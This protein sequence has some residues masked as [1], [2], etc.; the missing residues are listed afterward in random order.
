MSRIQ[1]EWKISRAVALSLIAASLLAA[2]GGGSDTSAEQPSPPP[3]G[4]DSSTPPA[5]AAAKKVNTPVDPGIVT[6]DNAFGL[7]LLA[8]L[9]RRSPG[10]NTAISPISVAM[11]LQ[12][13]YN[14]AQGTMQPAMAQ[15]LQ[16]GNLPSQLNADNAALLAARSAGQPL[17][18]AFH[19]HL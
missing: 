7:S 15:A 5:V 16:V 17:P 18:A 19:R 2:C 4:V 14:G 3:S 8:T 6:A 10:T 13:I 1:Y 12:I 11:C 9:T